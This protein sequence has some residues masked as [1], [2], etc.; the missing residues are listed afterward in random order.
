MRRKRRVVPEADSG[1]ACFS[2]Y[3]C[4]CNAL[5]CS[6]FREAA[7]SGAQDV[8][9]AFKACGAKPRCGRCF[10]DAASV[11]EQAMPKLA[12]L[13]AAVPAE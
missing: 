2:M 12:T 7:A 1:S 13:P 8:T 11:I 3:V 6:Q 9:S 4:I 10:E 5:K